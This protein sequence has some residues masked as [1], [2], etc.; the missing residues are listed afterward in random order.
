MTS[1]GRW[2]SHL[3]ILT[4]CPC[5]RLALI[6]SLLSIPTRI[7]QELPKIASRSI[8]RNGIQIVSRPSC[9]PKSW[10][11]RGRRWNTG[12][13]MLQGIS[14]I[15]WGRRMRVIIITYSE[16]KRGKKKKDISIFISLSLSL[17]Q[18]SIQC[19]NVLT[20]FFF[21]LFF[22]SFLSLLSH[23]TIL[24]FFLCSTQ[25]HVPIQMYES[26]LPGGKL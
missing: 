14:A 16:T 7:R 26:R 4:T 11:M 3:R 25:R 10:R 20:G 1:H 9:Y 12:Q 22:F 6:S 23:S 19:T 17:S 18:K 5:L 2:L 21:F 8:S 13:E 24:S 15:F